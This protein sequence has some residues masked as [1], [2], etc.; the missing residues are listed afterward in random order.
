MKAKILVFGFTAEEQRR[1]DDGLAAIGVPPVVRLRPSQARVSL[2]GI[3]RRPIF[4]VVTPTSSE[5]S[6]AEL[7]EHLVAER[8]ALEGRG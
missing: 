1:L 5:W 2:R 3:L 6:L 4:A 7:L 8:A